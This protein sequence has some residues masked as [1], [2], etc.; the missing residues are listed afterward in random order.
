LIQQNFFLTLIAWSKRTVLQFELD[1]FRW[2]RGKQPKKLVSR[3]LPS[4]RLPLRGAAHVVA[5]PQIVIRWPAA[6]TVVIVFLL[7]TI[8][9]AL[10]LNIWLDESYTLHTTEHGFLRGLREGVTFEVQAPLYFGFLGA[11]R[12]LNDSVFFA[13]AP[14]IAFSL[15]TL[16]YAWR[17][18]RRYLPRMAPDIV[19][20]TLALN[21][22]TIWAAV[23]MRPYA[24]AIALSFALVYYFFRGW[25]DA[26]V[27]W[28]ARLAFVAVSVVGAYTQYYVATL[29]AAGTLALLQANRRR[30]ISYILCAIGIGMLLAPIALFLP[31]QIAAYSPQA[32]ASPVP[33]YASLQALF[34]FLYPH[35]S[36]GS[37]AHHPVANALYFATLILPAV[38]VAR[39]P[40]TVAP[41]TRSLLTITFALTLIFVVLIGIFHINVVFPRQ[42]AILFGP[43][44]FSYFALFSDVARARR[45]TIVKTYGAIYSVL[46]VLALWTQ[47]H[48]LSKP[49]DWDKVGAF[50]N[51]HVKPNDAVAIFDAEA[52]LP[53][54][55]YFDALPMTAIPR[56]QS[57]ESYDEEA[58]AIRSESDLA[59]SL[60][61]AAGGRRRVWLVL[62]DACTSVPSFYGC[63]Y[64]HSYVSKHFNQISFSSFNGSSVIELASKPATLGFSS[65]EVKSLLSHA[66]LPTKAG[67]ALF[68]RK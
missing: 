68:E 6:V 45:I 17:F 53:L 24:A 23:E 44:L 42:T 37:L 28:R 7:L 58:F 13:R 65:P 10:R 67:V 26:E 59:E 34:Q 11:W 3:H 66:M 39:S 12:T 33:V 8:G 52:R 63:S 25:V 31:Q 61:R 15:V 21:P 9:L 16:V 19:L 60:G 40:R 5:Q 4:A 32:V 27:N 41:V 20:A 50:L 14:S 2:P 49:G 29:V 35:D 1:G 22:F 55:H 46:V 36:V 64:L 62:N 51:S 43:I 18:S 48:G 57:F 47:Y 38:L 30:F 56:P 54:S